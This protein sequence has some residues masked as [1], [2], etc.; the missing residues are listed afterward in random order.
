MERTSRM[1]TPKYISYVKKHSFGLSII[2]TSFL[3]LILRIIFPETIEFGY[4][5]PRL[6]SVVMDYINNGSYLKLQYFS[7]ATAWENLSWGPSLV[8]FNSLFLYISSD[9]ILVSYLMIFFNLFSVLLILYI[10]YEYFELS[11][12]IVAAIF[13]AT[14]PWWVVFSRMIYQPTPILTI[15]ALSTIFL[16]KVINN[17][18]SKYV[19]PLIISWGILIQMYLLTFSFIAASLVS[20]ILF[21]KLKINY[22]YLFCAI[23]ILLILY[24]PSFKYYIDNPNLFFKFFEFKG[25]YTT[26]FLD[27]FYSF[28]NN[29][30]GLNFRWQL[31][32]A[33]DDFIS[34]FFAYKTISILIIFLLSCIFLYG[35]YLI[36]KTKNKYGIAAVLI[37]VSPL[38]AIPLVGVEYI[39]PRY[40]L[41]IIPAFSLITS[42]SINS[43]LKH[44]RYFI[45]IPL[46]IFIFWIVFTIR[47]FNFISS[48]N[49][50]KGLLSLWSDTPY[51]YLDKSFKWIINDATS[52]YSTFTVS[53]DLEFPTENRFNDSQT[54]YWNYV[55]DGKYKLQN[56]NNVGHY[57]MYYAPARPQSTN[58]NQ[59][60]PYIIERLESNP[61]EFVDK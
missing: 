1:D 32:Y 18:K 34:T 29:M 17:P 19:L 57:L 56:S 8:L 36:L 44:S 11:V 39:V 42:I 12:G 9:P 54:Y 16:F 37:V 13:I 25:R 43:I 28:I 14:H 3:Y 24:I 15:V 7:L 49:Y 22:K 31:G 10:G 53:S 55:L 4:D 33:Y 35:V 23:L 46:F 2:F 41:Y 52:I 30:S 50:P 61:T 45:I 58:Y 51:Y 48:Y 21:T 26:Y 59:I 60:G 6:S 27:V 5:Q 47:Y 20:L 38:W 40:Y